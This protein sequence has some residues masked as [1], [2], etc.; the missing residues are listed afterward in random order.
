[1]IGCFSFSPEVLTSNTV[2][3]APFYVGTNAVIAAPTDSGDYYLFL[4][5]NNDNFNGTP[6]SGASF[7]DATAFWQQC[8]YASG[9]VFLGSNAI[10]ITGTANWKV[11]SKPFLAN[12]TMTN[13]VLQPDINTTLEFDSFQIDELV[14]SIFYQS[15][16]PL[17]PLRGQ[18]AMGAWRLEIWDNRSGPTPLSSANG[19]PDTGM[20]FNWSLRMT[21]ADSPAAIPLT[22][23]IAYTNIVRGDQ[24]KYFVVAVPKE[25]TQAINS[26][27]S[28]TAGAGVELLYSPFG[29]PTGQ[30][31]PDPQPPFPENP[32]FVATLTSPM[33][34]ELPLGKFYYLG[35]RNVDPAEVNGFSIR[36][37]FDIPIVQLR[38]NILLRNQVIGPNPYSFA[39]IRANT[40]L[41]VTNM[42]YYYFTI[43]S[44]NTVSATFSLF[45]TTDPAAQFNGDVNLVL[46]RA[47]PVVDLFPRPTFFDYESTHPFLAKE[48]IIVNSNSLPVKLAP[49]RWYVG[50]YNTTN[51]T[52]HYDILARSSIAT[53]PLWNYVDLTNSVPTNF[54]VLSPDSFTNFYRFVV[55]Q[56]NAAVLFEIYDL[57][58]DA[59]LLVKRSDLPAP[60]LYDFSFLQQPNLTE[61]VPLRTN[62]FIPH[63]NA[64]NW[65]LQIVNRDPNGGAV[66]G[67]VCAKVTDT[68]GMLFRCDGGIQ[69][70]GEVCLDSGCYFTNAIIF[71]TNVIALAWNAVPGEKYAI[72]Q[73]SDLRSWSTATNIVASETKTTFIAPVNRTGPP[74][75]YRIKQLP[76]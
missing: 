56:T 58:G 55:D 14:S 42:N 72:E 11:E 50:V 12:S 71:N 61:L 70:A 48:E 13:L 27:Q 37:D 30:S 65:F 45:P 66:S 33:G 17:N 24:I 29:L 53:A 25:V 23:G 49:G 59:D 67:T 4:G 54:T 9:N 6:P 15:E 32:P 60:D 69:I 40:P 19:N 34:A 28:T 22:N 76:R 75:F 51:A 3:S 62:I 21:F 74:R 39:N 52:A 10:P 38:N 26:V 5:V 35:V 63:I 43:R 68:N 31:P 7:Y 73:T 16:E 20:L 44:T 36:V 18:P 2:A 1:L 47:L 8:Q 57:T 64:T 46:R 41:A